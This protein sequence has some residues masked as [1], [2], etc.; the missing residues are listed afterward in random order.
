MPSGGDTF[1]FE[2]EFGTPEPR[3]FDKCQ[4]LFELSD[5]RQVCSA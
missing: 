2:K 3:P 1:W 5:D 4:Q